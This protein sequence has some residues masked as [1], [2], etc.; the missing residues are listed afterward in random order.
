MADDWQ[1]GDLAL[2]ISEGPDPADW[3]DGGGPALGSVTAVDAVDLEPEGVFLCFDEY[4]DCS[5]YN[6]AFRKIRPHLPD[7][8]DA[9]TL[10]LLNG[11]PA[12]I[13]ERIS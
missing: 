9:E 6:L 4:P 1:V 10:R 11:A 12:R 8:E 5:F 3:R 2:C 7:A 13:K